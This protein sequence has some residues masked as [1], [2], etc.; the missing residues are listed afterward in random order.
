MHR[1]AQED[2][3]RAKLRKESGAVI[4][5]EEME[6][7]IAT[8][9]PKPG[10]TP[11]VIKQKAKARETAIQGM[12]KAAGPAGQRINAPTGTVRKYN[13]ATGRIE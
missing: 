7:E 2:W 1:Q 13:P 9:F 12:K 11:Q 6:R 5:D 4:A 8:Y 10:D 3:V